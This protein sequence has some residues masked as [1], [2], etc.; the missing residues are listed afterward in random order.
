MIR[1]ILKCS[2]SSQALMFAQSF[3]TL[4]PPPCRVWRVNVCH[5]SRVTCPPLTAEH[6]APALL[7]Q[8]VVAEGSLEAG[9]ATP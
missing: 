4:S 8:P 2:M 5:V 9:P 7:H 3:P 1:G 6:L